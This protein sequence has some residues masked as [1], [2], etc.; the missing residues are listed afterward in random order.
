MPTGGCTT[1]PGYHLD[2]DE[3]VDNAKLNQGFDP[4][5]QVDEG[6]INDREVGQI[7]PSKIGGSGS[8]TNTPDDFQYNSPDFVSGIYLDGQLTVGSNQFSSATAAFTLDDEGRALIAPGVPAGTKIEIAFSTT[9][10]QLSQRALIEITD[11]ILS[12]GT[13]LT[14]VTAAFIGSDSGKTVASD[15]TDINGATITYVNATTVTLSQSGSD[16]SGIIFSVSGRVVQ[17]VKFA[18]P[19]RGAGWALKTIDG[20]GSVE[21][22]VGFFGGLFS[23]GKFSVSEDGTMSSGTDANKL[24]IL[25]GDAVWGTSP[26]TLNILRD[27]K[28][29]S[30]ADTFTNAITKISEEGN[31]TVVSNGFADHNMATDVM[32]PFVNPVIMS[33][34]GGA[35]T[36]PTNIFLNCLTKFNRMYYRSVAKD[37]VTNTDTSFVS[38]TAAFFKLDEGKLIIGT[39]IPDNTY[40][41]TVTNAT[42]IVLT[43]ATTGTGTA[44]EFYIVPNQT[45]T[46]Y[47]PGTPI[48]ITA[49]RKIAARAYKS[50]EYSALTVFLYNLDSTTCQN[51]IYSPVPGT[52]ATTDGTLNVTLSDATASASVYYTKDGTAPAHDGGY[53]ASGT[54]VKITAPPGTINLITGTTVL[55][56]LAGLSGKTDSGITS[57]TYIITKAGSG[58]QGGGGGGGGGGTKPPYEI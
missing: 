23:A 1:T 41:K 8:V 22:Y 5:V 37:G 9:I 25:D 36:N 26:R 14:S 4:V 27:G 53:A 2:Q 29:F 24:V 49:T 58:G 40:I 43:A 11:G 13:T 52:Y 46:L 6:A 35:V 20:V 44:L 12:G 7:S 16:A 31:I 50:G 54:S 3:L 42:T 47:T 38:A 18:I 39:N 33:P 17:N 56:A 57:G 32:N 30:G 51:P 45:D 15:N 21:D 55:K 34:Q 10:V 19:D 48:V 28:F